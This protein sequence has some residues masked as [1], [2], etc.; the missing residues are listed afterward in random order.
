MQCVVF[1]EFDQVV[2][3]SAESCSYVL[4]K[5]DD[6]LASAS[7]DATAIAASFTWGF[8]VVIGLWFLSYCVKAALKS[9]KLI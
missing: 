1:N 5:S 2:K 7:L 4:V 3:S 8:G 6:F 9:I